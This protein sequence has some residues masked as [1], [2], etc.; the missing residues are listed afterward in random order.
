MET[1]TKGELQKLYSISDVL[2]S[3]GCLSP[4]LSLRHTEYLKAGTITGFP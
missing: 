1:G 4:S 3:L 2:G